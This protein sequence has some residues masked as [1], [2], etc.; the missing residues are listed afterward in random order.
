MLLGGRFHYAPA[1]EHVVLGVVVGV[2]EGDRSD[3]D[4]HL[5]HDGGSFRF[6]NAEMTRAGSCS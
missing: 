6:P 1:L 3:L 2:V 4:V 5:L